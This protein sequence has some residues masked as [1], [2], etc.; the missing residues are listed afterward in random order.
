MNLSMQSKP[1]KGLKS[2]SILIA[3]AIL[4]TSAGLALAQSS[5]VIEELASMPEGSYPSAIVYGP[6]QDYWLPQMNANAIRYFSDPLVQAEIALAQPDSVP[7][8]AVIGPDKAIWFTEKE[9][10]SIG[11]LAVTES[12][13]ITAIALSEYALGQTNADPTQINLTHD[14]KMAFT[15]FNADKIGFS[16]LS[17][18]LSEIPLPAGTRPMSIVTDRDGN[19]WFSGWG[20]RTLGKIN[21]AGELTSIPTGEVAFR[22]TEMMRDQDGYI[23][24]LLDNARRIL[25]LDPASATISSHSIPALLSSSFVDIA[26]GVDGKIWLLGNELIGWFDHPEGGP[27]NFQELELD[28]KIFEGQGRAQLAAGPDNHMIFTHNNDSVLRQV[29]VPGSLL[30][31]LQVVVVKMHP[32]VLAAGE[33][34]INL[35]V[36]N[37]SRQAADEVA[38]YLDLDA[39]IEFVGIDGIDPADCT[40]IDMQVKCNLGSLPADDNLPLL[41][42]YRTTRI[43]GYNVERELAFTV[44][45][46]N[47]DYQ[48]GNDR[49]VRTFT[50]QRSIDYF[51]DFEVTA[52]EDLWSHTDLQPSA[53]ASQT[54]GRFSNDNVSITFADLPPHDRVH[55]CFQLYVM[56]A[57]DGN[58]FRDPDVVVEP[59]PL[60][61]PDIWA[62]YINEE[63]LVVASFSNQERFTQSF[64]AN[65]QEGSHAAQQGARLLGDFDNDG[66]KN[67]ARYDFCYTREHRNETFRTTFYGVNLNPEQAESWSLD[68]VRTMVYYNAVFDWYY[69]PLLIR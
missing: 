15:E 56:G 19:L 4:F 12:G 38:I 11:K 28:P 33:F 26:L 66:L 7:Y 9:N 43:P 52:E 42:T 54:L 39:N 58:Q 34:Y 16:T 60:I 14:G 37:W 20:S 61:G 47:G 13:D 10:A 32:L 27:Q 25:R 51:N 24:V 36:V 57:W 29:P 2:L 69:L 30:R 17:G 6:G 62:N 64:P 22:P 5:L 31:D 68:N 40:Q 50:I 3:V 41:V 1:K 21:S 63:R 65:Y 55:V 45:L 49:Q 46:Q 35:E 8:D 44:L 67:D 53:T 18:A 59:V 48:P 23:W